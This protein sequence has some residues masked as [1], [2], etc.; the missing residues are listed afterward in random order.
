MRTNFGAFLFVFIAASAVCPLAAKIKRAH[1]C[2]SAH[3]AVLAKKAHQ[4]V[5]TIL[6]KPAASLAAPQMI[7]N[8]SYDSSTIHDA[9]SLKKN[10][11]K[12]QKVK[13]VTRTRV[14]PASK[15]RGH[16]RH[17][18]K[19]TCVVRRRKIRRA[20][21]ACVLPH[22]EYTPEQQKKIE[23]FKAAT[24]FIW[25]LEKSK[26]RISSPYGYRRN[27]NGTVGFHKGIDM[28]ATKGTPVF[29]V[30]DAIVLD[31]RPYK[32][33]G[34]MILLGHR[35]KIFTRYAHLKS[36]KVKNGQ[37]VRKGSIIGE[38]GNTGHV[39]HR[40]GHDGSHLH[41]ETYIKGKRVNP[42]LFV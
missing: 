25:P 15:N 31:A 42:R 16:V 13:S 30:D 24:G 22:K 19:R 4:T 5:Q 39:R 12:N 41:W 28:A 20:P 6:T 38:V 32:G 9:V 34:N 8:H 18:K 33:Y 37:I 35:H 1:P 11:N 10:P 2:K 3:N 27:P 23:K 29:A 36:I 17:K 21:R 40:P 26:F 14:S 7:K